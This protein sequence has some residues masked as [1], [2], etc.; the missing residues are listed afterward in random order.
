MKCE[1]DYVILMERATYGR[2]RAG[3][4]IGPL[5]IGCNADVLGRDVLLETLLDKV[6]QRLPSMSLLLC[7]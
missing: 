6:K 5:N 4:C 1:E 3:R 2:M 7:D